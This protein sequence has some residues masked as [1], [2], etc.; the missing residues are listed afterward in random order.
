MSL[1][2]D[3]LAI[4]RRDALGCPVITTKELEEHLKSAAGNNRTKVTL[5]VATEKTGVKKACP[6]PVGAKVSTLS[7]FI[8]KKAGM[9]ERS[10]NNQRFKEGVEETFHAD[11]PNYEWIE[12]GPLALQCGRLCVPMKVESGGSVYY[13]EDG[14]VLDFSTIQEW[15]TAKS[16]PKKQGLDKPSVWRAP[17]SDNVIEAQIDGQHFVVMN[18]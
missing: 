1:T 9:Y 15:L 3:A 2:K 11:E 13:G 16:E 5:Y 4:Q 8:Q 7:G 12:E 6:I 17:Y 14:T 10:V 18:N